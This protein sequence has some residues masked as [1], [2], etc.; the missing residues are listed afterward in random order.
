MLSNRLSPRLRQ[1]EIRQA[2]LVGLEECPFCEWK[3][4]VE[5]STEEDVEARKEVVNI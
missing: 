4:V 5:V 1:K 3:C 2:G